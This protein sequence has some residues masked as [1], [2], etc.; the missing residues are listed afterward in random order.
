MS[1]ASLALGL[2]SASAARAVEEVSLVVDGFE[3]GVSGW[4]VGSGSV[5]SSVSGGVEGAKAARLSYDVSAGSAVVSRAVPFVA[6]SSVWGGLKVDVKGDGTFNTLYAVVVDATGE[7]FTYRLDSLSSSSWKTFGV[8]LGAPMSVT[9][10][11]NDKVLDAPLSLDR[12]YVTRNTSQPAQ[13][14]V[15]IDRV[16]FVGAGWSS[17]SSSVGS[18][19]PSEGESASLSFSAPSV[20]DY[21]IVLRDS[22]NRSRQFS[23][24]VSAAGTQTVSWDGLDSSGVPMTGVVRGTV[25]HDD[26]PDGSLAAVPLSVTVNVGSVVSA[27]ASTS[28]LE[29]FDGGGAGWQVSAGSPTV[30]VSSERVEGSG[31]LRFGYDLT[32]GRAEI[33]PATAKVSSSQVFRHLQVDV[34][35][36]GTGNTLLATL[37]DASGEN[38][39]YTLDSMV[40][41]TWKT[42]TIDLTKPGAVSAGNGD[43][44]LDAPVTLS[45]VYVQRSGTRP[46]TGAVLVDNVRLVGDGWTTPTSSRAGF[47]PSAGQTTTIDFTAGSAGD[48][49][50]ALTDPQGKSRAIT[51]TVTAAGP[52]S[53]TFDGRDDSGAVMTGLIGATLSQDNTPDNTLTTPATS[54]NPF[55]SGVSPQPAPARTDSPVALNADITYARTVA[56][57]DYRAGL[58][59]AAGVNHV[60]EEFGWGDIEQRQGYFTWDRSDYLVATAE[61][62]NLSIIGRL[63]M[64][65]PWASSAPADPNLSNEDIA[66]YPPK[67]LDDYIDYVRATVSRY[68]DRVHH[69]E[70]WNE[71][72]G[73]LF[74]RPQEDAEAYAEMLKRTYAAIKEIDPTAVVISGG[75]AGFDHP[76]MEKLRAAGAMNS[77]DA[78]GLHTF[79]DN[80]PEQSEALT[81][82]EQATAYLAR[83][84][85][86]K[87]IWITE[88]S[89]STCTPGSMCSGGV[90]EQAQAEYLS[91]FYAEAAARG[92]A[93]VA[94]WNLLEWGDT[95]AKLDNYGLV[96]RSG[97]QKPAY[98]AL[99]SVGAAFRDRAVVGPVSPTSDDAGVLL[100]DM[101]D[102]SQWTLIGRNLGL[103]NLTFGTQR[104]GGSL[105]ARLEYSFPTLG[106]GIRMATD[107]PVS[108]RP[109]SLSVWMYGDATANNVYIRFVDSQGEEFQGLTGHVGPAGWQR[110]VLPLDGS[111]RDW[112]SSGTNANGVIDYPIRVTGV[113]ILQS[114]IFRTMSGRVFVD[115]LSAHYGVPT[116]GVLLAGSSTQVRAVT[117]GATGSAAFASPGA[118]AW[119]VSQNGARTDVAVTQGTATIPV[120]PATTYLYSDLTAAPVT[121]GVGG[122]ATIPWLNGEDTVVSLAVTT[123]AG[124]PVISLRS[125]TLYSAGPA[126]VVWNTRNSAGQLVPA[127]DYRAVLTLVAPTGSR[128]VLTVPIRVG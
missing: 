42:V 75:L 113:T 84:A 83:Y 101:A 72:D 41:S 35:P 10:G 26:S 88:V 58:A 95:N 78:F 45:R 53:V 71:P 128:S 34:K 48:Y 9:G 38:F 73:P 108:G 51:G 120:G 4:S 121:A 57:R 28:V 112:G 39:T 105:G 77:F 98:A 54:G 11:S 76:F 86:G 25:S 104:H 91:K 8:A 36:D 92:V 90:S 14:T 47:A 79:V 3:S 62:Y 94:W 6:D 16:R 80:A 109:T 49:Q 56:D 29:S 67:D 117:A 20:G 23:G 107:V 87:K 22:L 97:R 93:S 103:G 7:S 24:T 64:S 46:V 68:H 65:A 1:L 82:I 96:E 100:S 115:D 127:G 50:L 43:R 126:R 118:S 81:W 122:Y 125:G 124:A 13:G 5:L 31:S 18:F 66:S 17:L 74:W 106:G 61:A 119:A 37:V 32:S 123:P 33:R 40:T 114:P 102:A 89:W 70:V 2:L 12:L 15:L 55:A 19:S 30:G 21:G 116:R 85:P 59:A 52:V 44:I 110:M 99:K 111:G 69:W 60:R 63:G 27:E